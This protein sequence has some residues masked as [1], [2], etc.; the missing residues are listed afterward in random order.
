[1]ERERSEDK[2]ASIKNSVT[3]LFITRTHRLKQQKYFTEKCSWKIH[4]CRTYIVGWSV[5]LRT[6]VNKKHYH[7]TN[8]KAQN[9]HKYTLL[10]NKIGID[11]IRFVDPILID[12]HFLAKY[13]ILL[14][15]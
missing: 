15:K 1:M 11:T 2:M 9:V 7:S 12:M 5:S 3:S 6:T 8:L 10:I 13:S 14:R 4:I